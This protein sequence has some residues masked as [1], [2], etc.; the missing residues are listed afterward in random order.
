[1]T[2]AEMI[3]F[4]KDAMAGRIELPAEAKTNVRGP[5]AEG[6]DVHRCLLDSCEDPARTAMTVE[7][8]SGQRILNL[9]SRHWIAMSKAAEQIEVLKMLDA[10]RYFYLNPSTLPN[11]PRTADPGPLITAR[12]KEDLPC[13]VCGKQAVVALYV[14]FSELNY[15]LDVCP[16]HHWPMM[17]ANEAA[18]DDTF[19]EP[20]VPPA[21][22]Q[23]SPPA[24]DA[25]QVDIDPAVP[26]GLTL[27]ALRERIVELMELEDVAGDKPVVMHGTN[28]PVTG[29]SWKFAPDPSGRIRFAVFVETA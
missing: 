26:V 11:A 8:A 12:T 18:V 25:T 21:E 16:R 17:K 23:V 24:G 14:E 22:R 1:M 2:H 6:E 15:W 27:A 28:A 20:F 3:E 13:S 10:L 29:L 5:L 9:C 19:G 7:T 4:L